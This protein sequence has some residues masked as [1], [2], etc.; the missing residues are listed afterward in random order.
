MNIL[1]IMNTISTIHILVLGLCVLFILAGLLL[2]S[3]LRKISPRLQPKKPVRVTRLVAFLRLLGFGFVTLFLMFAAL[4]A[5]EDNQTVQA[6]TAPAFR[7]VDLPPNLTLPVENVFFG[8]ANGTPMAAWYVPSTNGATIILLHGYGGTRADM[9]WHAD[10]LVK[11]GYGVLL[12]DERASGE[13]GGDRRSYGWEDGPDVGGAIRYIKARNGAKPARIGI[14]GCSMGA[15]IA[16]QGAIL[17]PEIAAVWADGTAN[18]RAVDN[19]PPQNGIEGAVQVSNYL[20][21][22]LYE[23]RLGISAPPPMIDQIH[24]IAPRPVMLV[25]GGTDMGLFGT[26]ADRVKHF[27]AFA[28]PNTQTW[29]IAE[30]VHC[31]GPLKQPQEYARRIVQFFDA[32]FAP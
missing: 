24:L 1:P 32:A 22:F 20:I 17:Y 10:K 21:D 26:E 3:R 12:Y 5:Y 7:K 16:L 2:I 27:A 25:G 6:E 4:L 11:A 30:V 9:L 19:P 29:I 23:L 13:S 18:I 15:Q 14:G 8:G 31:D 28:G